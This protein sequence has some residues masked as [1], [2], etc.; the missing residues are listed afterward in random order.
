MRTQHFIHWKKV[1]HSS[2]K[3][4]KYHNLHF[5]QGPSRPGLRGVP[6]TPGLKGSKGERGTPGM[7]SVGPP[8][9]PGSP[10]SPGF[11]GSPGPPG[12][13][14]KDARGGPFCVDHPMTGADRSGSVLFPMAFH[15]S[16]CLWER[17]WCSADC[18]CHQVFPWVPPRTEQ[19]RCRYQGEK[20]ARTAGYHVDRG[21]VQ[22]LVQ[23]LQCIS[24]KAVPG[25]SV[26]GEEKARI[27]LSPAPASH[28]SRFAPQNVTNQSHH[29]DTPSERD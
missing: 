7:D 23:P 17:L 6:G 28:W 18:R 16:N 3:K 4:L 9:A 22:L 19:E 15:I 10:G 12:P 21:R 20:P 25:Q 13:P 27:Y 2:E 5:L 8:G 24:Y 11:S 29:S 26:P 14:G 1:I